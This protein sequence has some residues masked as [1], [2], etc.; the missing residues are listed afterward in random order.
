MPAMHE[1]SVIQSLLDQ[2]ERFGAEYKMTKVTRV[3]IRIGD[4]VSICKESLQFAFDAISQGT[5]VEGAEFVIEQ[6]AGR[7]LD[8]QTIEGEQEETTGE[9]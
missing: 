8:L 4:Q 3:V 2:V 5:L 6:T 7:E 9:N 1:V